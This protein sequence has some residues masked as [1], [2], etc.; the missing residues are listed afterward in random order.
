[1]FEESSQP[2]PSSSGQSTSYMLRSPLTMVLSVKGLSLTLYL[3][4][5]NK[6]IGALLAQEVEGINHQV[7]YLSR[8]VD[9]DFLSVYYRF[10]VIIRCSQLIVDLFILIQN[11]KSLI[12][13]FTGYL[14]LRNQARI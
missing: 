10:Q 12:A 7:Y 4:F 8:P 13:S 14:R 5:L 9:N 3:T 1:M 2:W 11:T 6:S